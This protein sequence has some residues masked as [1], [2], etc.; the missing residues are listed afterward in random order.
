MSQIHSLHQARSGS[1]KG[2]MA[3]MVRA[4]KRA[5]QIAAQTQTAL[6]VQ[7]NG[8]LV[9]LHQSEMST[10]TVDPGSTVSAQKD[11]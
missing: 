1:L 6:V 4:A 10:L 5:R 2:S 8:A 11:N 3:A 9:Y 7:R